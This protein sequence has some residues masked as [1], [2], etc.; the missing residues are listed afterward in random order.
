ML[1][2]GFPDCYLTWREQVAALHS[3]GFRLLL[4][5]LRGYGRS[6]APSATAEYSK[7]AVVGDLLGLL[8][9]LDIPQLA[10]LAG[11]DWGGAVAYNVASDAPQRIAKLAILNAPHGVA[12]GHLLR[13]SG[14]QRR[15]S[16]YMLFF[17]LPLLPELLLSA[18]RYE[19]IRRMLNTTVGV[20]V[21]PAVVD[22]YVASFETS[23]IRG[24]LNY[25]RASARGLWR[26]TLTP[27]PRPT[28]V[29]WGD[30]DPYLRP[31]LAR[32]P[33]ALVPNAR[34][35]R[36]RDGGHWVQATSATETNAALL[37]LLTK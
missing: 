29:V 12:L 22:K 35:V 13:T 16:W 27:M 21:S 19:A 23:G 18:K 36:V 11:H 28:L 3:A 2:H 10:C 26:M 4:P 9:A 1:L 31:E 25:Y 30:G 17:Q 24:P 14:D 6:Y 7:D 15:R 8:D 20:P 32:P 33:A 37:A 34:V 5:S